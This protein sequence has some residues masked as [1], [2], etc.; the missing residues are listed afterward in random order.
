MYRDR[1]KLA[2]SL[3]DDEV[4]KDFQSV[5]PL[6]T[7]ILTMYDD[8]CLALAKDAEAKSAKTRSATKHYRW[9]KAFP[10][11]GKSPWLTPYTRRPS[12]RKVPAGWVFPVLAAARQYMKNGNWHKPS[13]KPGYW[14][15]FID[16]AIHWAE[17]R[18]KDGWTAEKYGKSELTYDCLYTHISVSRMRAK[19]IETVGHATTP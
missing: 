13:M 3:R 17:M 14:E 8:I 16:G 19:E 4:L 15:E 6:A 10:L 2:A 18:I 9:E 11:A 12:N 7:S 1:S 5:A